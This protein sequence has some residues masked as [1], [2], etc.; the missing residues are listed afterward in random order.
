MDFRGIIVIFF[1]LLVTNYAA[2][3]LIK[4]LSYK[5]GV[6]TYPD[7][8]EIAFG[9]MGK[10]V[11]LVFFTLET[12]TSTIP[13][14]ILIGDSLQVLFP[15]TSII[16]LKIISWT[17]LVP[18]TLIDINTWSINSSIFKCSNIN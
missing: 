6:Y 1:G 2:I 7:I 16:L 5:E 10:H 17:I 15:N 18:L 11:I 13:L 12:I 3:I 8:A 4:C 14:V 9:K